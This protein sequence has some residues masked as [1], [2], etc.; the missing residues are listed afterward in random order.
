MIAGAAPHEVGLVDLTFTPF[1]VS[2]FEMTQMQ[3]THHVGE[4]PSYYQSGEEDVIPRRPVEQ[5]SL[6]ECER[7][8]GELG[9]RIP[10]EEEW[11]YAVRA[12]PTAPWVFGHDRNEAGKFGNLCD[13]VD[14]AKWRNKQFGYEEWLDDGMAD[15]ASVGMYLANHFGLHDV[16]GNVHE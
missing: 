15:L 12:G 14:Q 9:L 5:V 7:V 8:I 6:R 11:E 10:T 1:F 16:M 13:S 2:K 4:N 3:W